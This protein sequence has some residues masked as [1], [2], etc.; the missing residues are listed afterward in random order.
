MFIW[1]ASAQNAIL[2]NSIHDNGGLG[3]H[4][5]NNAND[6]Q[7][8]PVL[9]AAKISNGGTAISGTL[10][11]VANTSFRIEFF[12]N[13]ILNPSGYGEGRTYLGFANVTTNA[14]GN[15]MFTATGL[16][17]LPAGQAYLSLPAVT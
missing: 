13:I 3:I 5:A 15:A 8:S 6:N 16:S 14:S 1:D 11:S 10:S 12:S 7:T 4:L 9:T 2:G 17:A